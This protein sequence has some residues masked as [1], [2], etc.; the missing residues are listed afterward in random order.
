MKA[1]VI[2]QGHTWAYHLTSNL[3][4]GRGLRNGGDLIIALVA[5]VS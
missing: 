4:K 1:A 5:Q 3:N 2:R